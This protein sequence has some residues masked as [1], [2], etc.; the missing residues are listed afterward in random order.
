MYT[1]ILYIFG[2]ILANTIIG[3]LWYLPQTFGSMWM[4]DANV[5]PSATPKKS[6]ASAIITSIVCSAVTATIMWYVHYI[7]GFT[8]LRYFLVGITLM[9]VAFVV[10]IRLTHSMF[11][12]R[13]IRYNIITSAHD[14]VSLLAMGSI[15]YFA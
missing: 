12:G 4:K 3:A 8:E 5:D 13:N 10:C 15:V 1:T 11:E 7:L 9:W 6:M 14:L 2:A